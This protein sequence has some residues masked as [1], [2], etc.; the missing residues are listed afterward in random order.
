MPRENGTQIRSVVRF[1]DHFSGLGF[2]WHLEE[3]FAAL[4]LRLGSPLGPFGARFFAHHWWPFGNT[5]SLL[6]PPHAPC[7]PLRVGG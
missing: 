7:G 1:S 2:A 5:F 6:H 4:A 3:L